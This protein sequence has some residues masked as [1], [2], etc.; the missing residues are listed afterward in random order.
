MILEVN[1]AIQVKAKF[2]IKEEAI[3]DLLP[4]Q[5]RILSRRSDL[6]QDNKKILR[7]G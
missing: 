4:Q 1:I 7:V 6:I 2:F 3:N 5:L